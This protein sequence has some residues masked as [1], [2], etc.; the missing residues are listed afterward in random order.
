[1]PNASWQDR[2]CRVRFHL[3]RTHFCQKERSPT[4][5]NH[6]H[7]PELPPRKTD[8]DW[9]DYCGESIFSLT[10][11]PNG[12]IRAELVR[13]GTPISLEVFPLPSGQTQ[14]ECGS[15]ICL[16]KQGTDLGSRGFMDQSHRPQTPSE[17]SWF[18]ISEDPNL[19][20][21]S[22]VPGKLGWRQTFVLACCCV[23]PEVG[24]RVRVCLFP[25]PHLRVR[26]FCSLTPGSPGT[27][28]VCGSCLE[29]SGSPVWECPLLLSQYSLRMPPVAQ[30][31]QFGNAPCSSASTVWECPL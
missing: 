13:L 8:C 4:P 25:N 16:G 2:F 29:F 26:C 10:P 20:R 31:V 21:I 12:G 22:S 15:S 17:L 5:P 24:A 11:Q 23:E 19:W 6:P 18:S 14:E 28:P 7:N 27:S 3:Q 1:M 30:P 9:W